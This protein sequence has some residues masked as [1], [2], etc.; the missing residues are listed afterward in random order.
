M[1]LNGIEN[2][3]QFSHIIDRYKKSLHVTPL[4]LFTFFLSSFVNKEVCAYIL[5]ERKIGQ[6]RNFCS[7][8]FDT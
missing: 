7:Y 4:H 8:R 1:F 3:K 5:Y 6:L 2:P